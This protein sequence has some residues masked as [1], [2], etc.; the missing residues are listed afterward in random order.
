ML[1]PGLMPS[2]KTR[3]NGEDMAGAT[4]LKMTFDGTGRDGRPRRKGRPHSRIMRSMMFLS[5]CCARDELR[6]KRESRKTLH[7]FDGNSFY[8]V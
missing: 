2:S 6:K 1:G 4:R 8:W 3:A 7:F 5:F